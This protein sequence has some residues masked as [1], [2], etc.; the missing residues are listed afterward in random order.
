MS[1]ERHAV[2]DLVG[3]P[4]RRA[5]EPGPGDQARLSR[6]FLVKQ[7]NLLIE[8]QRAA[9]GL[10]R[11]IAGDEVRQDLRSWAR[12]LQ[13]RKVS[14]C[15]SLSADVRTLGA[16]PSTAVG[17][18]CDPASTADDLGAR[19][20]ALHRQET[21][22][23]RRLKALLPRIAPDALHAHLLSMLAA[24]HHSLGETERIIRRLSASTPAATHHSQ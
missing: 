12:A 10:A 1:L 2:V 5:A 3:S 18:L 22:I 24:Q 14:W 20:V 15:N 7:L 6:E 11:T 21:W 8:A 9:A 23:N 17:R 19:L 4:H 16:S 13:R